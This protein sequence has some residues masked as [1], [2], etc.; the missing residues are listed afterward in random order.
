MA[1]VGESLPE[2]LYRALGAEAMGETTVATTE[3]TALLTFKITVG[4]TEL[5]AHRVG[6]L[7]TLTVAQVTVTVA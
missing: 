5:L 6:S 1:R 4:G 7:G 2:R 3:A